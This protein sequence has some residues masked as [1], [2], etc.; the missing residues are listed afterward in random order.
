MK[1]QFTILITA[2]I[3]TCGLESNAFAQPGFLAGPDSL[4][5]ENYFNKS[6]KDRLCIL[7]SVLRYH[8][9]EFGVAER[10]LV[11]QE[12]VFSFCGLSARKDARF[13]AIPGLKAPYFD[14]KLYKKMKRAFRKAVKSKTWNNAI[15]T[16]ELERPNLEFFQLASYCRNSPRARESFALKYKNELSNSVKKYIVED[17]AVLKSNQ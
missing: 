11:F 8:V 17:L 7:D 13:Y 1:S 15:V 5:F 2:A 4:L 3:I 9:S 10:I 6:Y 14:Y 12:D 16:H